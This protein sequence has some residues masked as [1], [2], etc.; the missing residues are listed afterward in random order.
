MHFDYQG[1]PDFDFDSLFGEPDPPRPMHFDYQG[2][3]DFDF[4]Q[5]F[6]EPTEVPIIGQLQHPWQHPLWRPFVNG[7]GVMD[8]G[9]ALRCSVRSRRGIELYTGGLESVVVEQLQALE[10]RCAHRECVSPGRVMHCFRQHRG[11][12]RPTPWLTVATSCPSMGHAKACS[13]GPGSRAAAR[14][15][16]LEIEQVRAE[17]PL[18]PE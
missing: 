2:D 9:L 14:R 16:R 8:R 17:F 10:C 18:L 3:P 1:D 6:L 7:D 12:W 5:Y 11:H 13:R 4:D 15:L